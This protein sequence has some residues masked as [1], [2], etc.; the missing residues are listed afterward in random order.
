[1][2]KRLKRTFSR[3][4]RDVV[5][6][7]WKQGVAFSDIDRVIDTIPGSIFTILRD[8][9]SIKPEK[10]KCRFNDLTI[11]ERE[12]IRIGLSAKMSIRAVARYFKSFVFTYIS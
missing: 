9:D 3:E 1:M 12:E 8:H 4:E 6:D 11:K 7:L 5:F 2:R 10:R